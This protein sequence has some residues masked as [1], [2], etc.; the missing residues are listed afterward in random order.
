MADTGDQR[1][2][3]CDCGHVLVW[4]SGGEL[5]CPRRSCELWGKPQARSRDRGGRDGEG[6]G[7][8]EAGE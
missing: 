5:V 1:Y 8:E 6:P 4:A 2:E 3:T 7:H